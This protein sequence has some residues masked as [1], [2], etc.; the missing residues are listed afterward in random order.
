MKHQGMKLSRMLPE[1]TTHM[2]RTLHEVYAIKRS[3]CCTFY[4]IRLP[5]MHAFRVCGRLL[6]CRG[7]EVSYAALCFATRPMLRFRN[8]CKEKEKQKDT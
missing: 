8:A 5:V 4:G 7:R 1:P 6:K 3:F 2:S